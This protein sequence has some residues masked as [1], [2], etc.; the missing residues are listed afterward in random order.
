LTAAQQQLGNPPGHSD[1]SNSSEDRHLQQLGQTFA[2]APQQM[3]LACVGSNTAQQQLESTI[4]AAQQQL[5]QVQHGCSLQAEVWKMRRAVWNMQRHQP[6]QQ[7]VYQQRCQQ[8]HYSSQ[9]SD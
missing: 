3:Q 8:H 7:Q 4:A 6:A 5:G 9:P 2:A 1:S